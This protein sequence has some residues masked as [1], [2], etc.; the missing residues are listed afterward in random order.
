[1]LASGSLTSVLMVEK[2]DIVMNRLKISFPFKGAIQ[3]LDGRLIR[4]RFRAGSFQRTSGF[5]FTRKT[6]ASSGV[7]NNVHA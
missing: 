5:T 6:R 2:I 4:N 7:R 3:K 1:M